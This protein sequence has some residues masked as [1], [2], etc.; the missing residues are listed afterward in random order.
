MTERFCCYARGVARVTES[1]ESFVAAFCLLETIPWQLADLAAR[2][3]FEAKDWIGHEE[4]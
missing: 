2:V 1:S 4:P 3:S